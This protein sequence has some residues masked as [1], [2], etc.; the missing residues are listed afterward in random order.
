MISQTATNLVNAFR[1]QI[2]NIGQIVLFFSDA[3]RLSFTRPYRVR[4]I[5]HHMDY[6][7]NKS[8]GIIVLTGVF[9]GLALSYQV[10]IGFSLVN[11]TNLVGPIV[12]LGISRELG[13][14][15]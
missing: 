5:M 10:Y 9:T 11:M 15:L 7:G 6:I 13:P 8:V 1:R 2:D 12:A 3:V 4:D 14:V